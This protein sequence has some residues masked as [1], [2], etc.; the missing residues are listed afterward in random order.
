MTKPITSRHALTFVPRPAE[1]TRAPG[2]A[3]R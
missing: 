2:I 3:A 1:A